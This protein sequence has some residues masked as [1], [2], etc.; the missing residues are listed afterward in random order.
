MS[1]S[2]EMCLEITV[3]PFWMKYLLNY[4][5]LSNFRHVACKTNDVDESG[6]DVRIV[7]CRHRA[8]LRRRS[9]PGRR[10][11]PVVPLLLPFRD[12]PGPVWGQH[13]ASVIQ[14]EAAGCGSGL[15]LW[16]PIRS[17]CGTGGE[18]SSIKILKSN[19]I[20]SGNMYF[21]RLHLTSLQGTV[22]SKM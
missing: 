11:K 7:S 14:P 12:D 18:Y 2:V 15:S 9:C 17:L 21:A 16:K 19:Q 3:Q 5:R 22:Y 10:V 1:L 8:R 4:S 6:T 20:L 13:S